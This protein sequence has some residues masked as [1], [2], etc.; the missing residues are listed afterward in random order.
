[1]SRRRGPPTSWTAHSLIHISTHPR[2]FSL[3]I[4]GI[5]A[6]ITGRYELINSNNY[7]DFLKAIGT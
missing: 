4:P 6:T 2:Y 7:L 1:M 3:S 5:M